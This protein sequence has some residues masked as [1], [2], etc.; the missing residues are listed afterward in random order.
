[1]HHTL[2]VPLGVMMPRAE[3]TDTHPKSTRVDPLELGT[4]ST[5]MFQ[6]ATQ[7]VDVSFVKKKNYHS[8]DMIKTT[9]YKNQN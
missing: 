9:T 1:M 4:L 8:H 7:L 6:F 5:E 3:L 2:D